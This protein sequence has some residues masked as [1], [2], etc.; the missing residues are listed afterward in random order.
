VQSWRWLFRSPLDVLEE[1]HRRYG[2]AFRL[3][4]L[5]PRYRHDRTRWPVVRRIMVVY[6][7]PDD[8][9]EIFA[10]TGDALRAGEA[11]E[12]LEFFVGPRSLIVMDGPEHRSERRE[13]LGLFTPERLARWERTMSVAAARA[14]DRWTPAR[15]IDLWTHVDH[16]VE[17][18]LLAMILPT[19]PE[20]T[21]RLMRLIRRARRAFA[22]PRLLLRPLLRPRRCAR[23]PDHRV[24]DLRHV[25]RQAV[26]RR[27]AETSAGQRSA[28]AFLVDLVLERYAAPEKAPL[29]AVVDRLVT[30]LAGMENTSAG[31][32]WTCLHLLRNPAALDRVRREVRATPG[33]IGPGSE[34]FLEAA[35]RE[36]LRLHPPFPAVMRRVTRPV[37]IGGFDLA[38]GTFVV[39][40]M[41]L[42][43]RRADLFPD[44]D[45]FRPERF[46]G[47]AV[48]ARG[49]L[50][51]GTGARR[52]P[53]QGFA[54]SQMRLAIA[55]MLRRF[56][57]EPERVPRLTAT[58][59]AASLVPAR[60]IRV[61]L[62][63][64]E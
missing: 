25:M 31:V 9:R 54:V 47:G 49:Y 62:W 53:G 58:R 41:Y 30:I 15:G 28:E 44:P 46:L 52:C 38:P 57:I 16:T 5:V 17:E 48:P 7:A 59:R 3:E 23:S 39:A 63:R 1:H 6:S 32:G 60:G 61:S 2:D 14:V 4:M 18:M 55:E 19:R 50:P 45:T 29:D 35:C 21:E 43:H 8:V 40:N 11:L 56:D 26:A 37:S 12:P 24:G 33:D 42:M 13:M 51:F 34:S 27:I 64:V 10:L 22:S 20:E 36:A